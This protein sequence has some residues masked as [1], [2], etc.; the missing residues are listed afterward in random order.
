MSEGSAFRRINA[1]RLA[2]RF[3]SLVGHIES[4]AVHLSTLVLLR[5]HLTES[6]IEE[7]VAATAR[8]T[9]R[10]VGE[11]LARRAPRPD[12]PSTIRKLPLLADNRPA[13]PSLGAPAPLPSAA[14][15]PAAR[16]DPLSESSRA[17]SPGQTTLRIFASSVVRTTGCTPSKSSAATTSRAEF[18]F[19]SESAPQRDPIRKL[20]T[21][22]SLR[23]ASGIVGRMYQPRV[24]RE[25]E[26]A[27]LHDLVDRY[28]F[29]VLLV[30]LPTGEIDI[31]HLPMLL[32]RD[33]G[34]K[35][36]LRM[37][38][39]TANPI[40]RAALAAGRATVVFSGPHGY[41]SAS[42]YE[43]PTEQVPTWNYAVV[44][45]HGTPRKME[46]VELL[47]LLDDLVSAHEPSAPEAWKTSVL[48]PALRDELLLEI[49]GLAIDVTTLEGKFKLS[50]NRSDTDRARVAEALRLRGTPDDMELV[51]LMS[52]RPES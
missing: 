16:I 15:R 22:R 40:W 4:G 11:L 17:P 8:K 29:G 28:S 13:T 7:L 47:Q 39:A 14:P 49:V 41:V 5:D 21:T 3:P 12:V 46:R 37:H 52:P 34:G 36:R 27:R 20:S 48:S 24:F 33:V 43:T 10:E 26:P 30:A 18:T 19:A 44:H 42:W 35:A 31:A 2:R 32:D 9:K 6:N 1:A 50:Q 23:R 25:E 51:R 38:L 45:A